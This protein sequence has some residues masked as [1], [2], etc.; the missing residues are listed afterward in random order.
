MNKKNLPSRR[1]LLFRAADRIHDR[2]CQVN[3][4]SADHLF[5]SIERM[6]A[7]WQVLDDLVNRHRKAHQ[8]CWELAQRQTR[9]DI[10]DQ[11]KLLQ[12]VV[13]SVLLSQEQSGPAQISSPACI[14]GELR[15]LADEF[16]D[17][18]ILTKPGLI[19]VKTSPIELE[20]LALGTFAI[21][22][23]LDR[24]KENADVTCFD[25]VAL[26]SNP[27]SANESIT[28]PHVKD[29]ALCA[30]EATVSIATALK[31]GRINDAFC[32]VRSVLTT[33]NPDSPY[34]AIED[35]DGRR[36]SDCGDVEDSDDLCCCNR[37]E[38]DFC[39][40][41]ISSCDICDAGFCSQC[42]ERDPVSGKY[43][44]NSCRFE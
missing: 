30:G 43:C 2:L 31:E 42:L 24:L 11:I 29:Q 32:L 34:V 15:Q 40:N 41:C 23:Y 28:H 6:R 14:V 8:N 5:A 44:C 19:V 20:G 18:D 9:S 38:N 25:C 37:C 7:Y 3:R 27:A 13:N 35:W 1:N 16:E 10:I 21:E 17:V 39:S 22:L 33:Y 12:E 4:R 26:D 36:C